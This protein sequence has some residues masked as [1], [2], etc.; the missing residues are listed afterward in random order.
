MLLVAFFKQLISDLSVKL[1]IILLNLGV[2]LPNKLVWR[3]FKLFN[4]YGLKI[5]NV[6]HDKKVEVSHH[7]RRRKPADVF[8]CSSSDTVEMLPSLT[9]NC[10]FIE[11]K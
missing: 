11:L 10:L 8:K 9:L 1:T 7:K 4:R 3:R 6:D 5:C 2:E